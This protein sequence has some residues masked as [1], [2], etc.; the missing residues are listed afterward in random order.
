[1][2]EDFCEIWQEV[3][4]LEVAKNAYFRFASS[5]SDNKWFSVE[6]MGIRLPFDTL[7]CLKPMT[8]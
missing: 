8:I 4:V 3:P 6:G 2:L 5:E 1:M 7:T